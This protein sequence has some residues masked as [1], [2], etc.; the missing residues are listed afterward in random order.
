MHISTDLKD[1]AV[2]LAKAQGAFEPIHKNKTMR[3]PGRPDYKY[4]DLADIIHATKPALLANGF[5]LPIGLIGKDEHGQVLTTLLLHSSGQFLQDAQTLGS[6]SKHQEFGV[7]LTYKRR[8]AY[9]ALLGIQAED[10]VDGHVEEHKPTAA[11]PIKPNKP[12]PVSMVPKA[13]SEDPGKRPIT[14][15]E[16]TMIATKIREIT[17]CSKDGV[18]EFVMQKTGKTE[19]K[20]LLLGDLLALEN[21]L[22][23]MMM[24]A[25][26]PF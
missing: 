13:H 24:D 8:Y 7:E 15:D 9:C 25:K 14:K 6:Y 2:A 5:C 11:S 18:I 21:E 12:S 4:A 17:K 22:G 23:L 26:L 20:T 3:I 16:W 1:L 10:D 19:P